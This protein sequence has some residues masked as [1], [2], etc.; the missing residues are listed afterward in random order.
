VEW[1][2][3]FEERVL[4]GLGSA[5]CY[6]WAAL[7]IRMRKGE[8]SSFVLAVLE[9]MVLRNA[10]EPVVQDFEGEMVWGVRDE[11]REGETWAFVDYLDTKYPKTWFVARRML[12][13]KTGV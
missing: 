2:H 5:G 8:V 12:T 4:E 6:R 10:P 13:V 7:A 1:Y 3:W 11:S 9:K